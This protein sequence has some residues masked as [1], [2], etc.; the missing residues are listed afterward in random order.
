MDGSNTLNLLGVV[1]LSTQFC[2]TLRDYKR[3]VTLYFNAVV[4]KTLR[5]MQ[6]YAKN[7]ETNILWLPATKPGIHPH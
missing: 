4:M 6:F 7:T 2:F 5:E 3:N 1:K